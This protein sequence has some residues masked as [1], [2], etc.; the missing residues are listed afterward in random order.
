MFAFQIFERNVLSFRLSRKENVQIP[1]EIR[2][3][4]L[5][6]QSFRLPVTCHTNLQ[7]TW[8]KVNEL[9]SVEQ[10]CYVLE[11]SV[12]LLWLLSE[13]ELIG[14]KVRSFYFGS[15]WDLY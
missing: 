2:L 14:A 11:G 9:I 5:Q 3:Q 15:V 8:I 6:L 13:D 1:H 7:F 12:A 10:V 4:M